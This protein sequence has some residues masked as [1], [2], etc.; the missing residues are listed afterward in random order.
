MSIPVSNLRVIVRLVVV[1][2]ASKRVIKETLL[3]STN[4]REEKTHI[5]YTDIDQG[6]YTLLGSTNHASST[7]M[8]IDHKGAL[9]FRTVERVVIV[10]ERDPDKKMSQ[11]GHS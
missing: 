1:N 9:E 8:L 3:H 10:A 4:T 5:E 2:E 11:V 6:L 7:R